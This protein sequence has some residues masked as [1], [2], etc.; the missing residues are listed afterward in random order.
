M[1]F[2]VDL[3]QIQLIKA[4][5]KFAEHNFPKNSQTGMKLPKNNLNNESIIDFF[6][7]VWQGSFD[8]FCFKILW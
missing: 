5:W 8:G 4:S 7:N 6:Q 2:E 3:F 1:I